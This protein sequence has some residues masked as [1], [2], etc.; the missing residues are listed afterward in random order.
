MTSEALHLALQDSG[1]DALKKG[2]EAGFQVIKTRKKSVKPRGFNQNQYVRAIREHD[3]NFGIGPAGT[4]K[5]FLAV[6][7]AVE[8][9]SKKN[10]A[11]IACAASGRGRRKIGVFAGRSAQKIDPYLR[12]LY[13]ALYELFGFERVEKLIERGLLKSLPCLHARAHLERCVY[14]SG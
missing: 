7:C 10:I 1:I 13:D 12:P 5:T 14:H 9:L 11:D 2:A 6:A 8:P 3:I 4:G